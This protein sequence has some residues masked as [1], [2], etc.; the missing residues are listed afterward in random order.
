M[1]KSNRVEKKKS[2]RELKKALWTIF[3]KYI[4]ARDENI[5]YT[6][7]KPAQHAGHYV[8]QSKGN[9]LRYDERNV[10]AQC[11]SCNSFRR[12]N[13]APYAL[14]LEKDYG[15]GILQEFDRIK[16]T[17]YKPTH[18]ELETKIGYYKLKLMELDPPW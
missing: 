12:G 15:A 5:C 1:K 7:G 13:L 3:S 8:P 16:Q 9:A 11:I 14:R 17:T 18:E 2:I 10:H 6:C 4:R